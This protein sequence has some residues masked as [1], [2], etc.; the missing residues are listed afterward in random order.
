MRRNR[1]RATSQ[2]NYDQLKLFPICF[3]RQILPSTFEYPL[4]HID[5]YRARCD[6]GSQSCIDGD[7]RYSCMAVY[8]AEAAYA[9]GIQEQCGILQG[10]PRP[11][12]WIQA[13]SCRPHS[14]LSPKKRV[15]SSVIPSPRGR[16]VCTSPMDT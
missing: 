10:I 12:R 8:R 1:W 7:S 13:R 9:R 11:S 2:C 5:Q 3:S 14:R 15:S 4:S 16:V 6:S